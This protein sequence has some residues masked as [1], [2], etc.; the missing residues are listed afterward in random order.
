MNLNH[1]RK[2]NWIHR[3]I[4]LQQASVKEQILSR[5]LKHFHYLQDFESCMLREK[6][7]QLKQGAEKTSKKRLPD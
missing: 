6:K 7:V 1:G 3:V 5:V 4:C 2:R